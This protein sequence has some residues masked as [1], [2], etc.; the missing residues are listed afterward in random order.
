MII[1]DT[2]GVDEDQQGLPFVGKAGTLLNNMIQSIGLTQEQVYIT[3]IIK[4]HPP[5]QRDPEPSEIA[6]CSQ[7]LAQQIALVQPKVLLAIGP[8]LGQY[9]LNSSLPLTE[10]RTK[11]HQYQGI[12]VMVSYHPADLLDNPKDKK[13]AYQDWEMLRQLL[14]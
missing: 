8:F 1:G 7:Y 9:L 6:Q 4:C 10:L 3:H 2:P 14:S 11:V 13:N 5:N 12:N